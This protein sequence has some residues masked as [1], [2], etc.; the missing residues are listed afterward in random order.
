MVLQD[1]GTVDFRPVTL[2]LQTPNYAQVVS[3]LRVGESR[4][5]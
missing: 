2:G 4:L 1:G 5:L 3:G